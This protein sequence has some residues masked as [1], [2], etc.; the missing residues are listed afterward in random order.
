MH[1]RFRKPHQTPRVTARVRSQIAVEAARRLYDVLALNPGEV[2]IRL[3][4]ATENEYYAAKRKAAAVLGHR[5]RPGD[6][7][8]DAEVREQVISLANSR[9]G[10]EMPVLEEDEHEEEPTL[11]AMADHVDRFAIYKMR[12]EPLELVK[13]NPFQHPEGDALFHSLQVFERARHL[14]PYDEEFLLAALLHDVGKAID[15]KAHIAAGVEALRGAVT[16]RTLWL[17]EHLGDLVALRERT[18]SQ[19]GRRILDE[20]EYL[21]DLKLLRDLDEAGRV[22]GTPVE[23]IDKAL[24]YLRGL[25]DEAYL[26]S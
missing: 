17:I 2:P 18:L 8:S 5:V 4:D 11:V 12:L 16:E 7:P 13:Q 20:S 25:E 26:D 24:A 6:L 9:A 22:P 10:I 19:R 3:G 23:T 1:D 14:R 15:P 21:D